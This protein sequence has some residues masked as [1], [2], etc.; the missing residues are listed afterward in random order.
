MQPAFAAVAPAAPVLAE[1][2]LWQRL[3]KSPT[4]AARPNAQRVGGQAALPIVAA[5]SLV[6]WRRR[7]QH[8]NRCSKSARKAAVVL[9]DIV[10]GKLT[11]L[12]DHVER[13]LKHVGVGSQDGVQ[14]E[15]EYIDKTVDIKNG[16]DRSWSLEEH[17]FTFVQDTPEIIDFYNEMDI[18]KKYYPA[19]QELVKKVTGASKV[20]AFYHTVRSHE[21]IPAARTRRERGFPVEAPAACVHVDYS[22]QCAQRCLRNLSKPPPQW[23]DPRPLLGFKP[24]IASSEADEY[25]MGGKRWMIV[26]VWRNISAV[27]VQRTPVALCDGRTASLDDI[28]TFQARVRRHSKEYY[29]SAF[30]DKHEWFYFPHA[31]RDEAILVKNWDSWGEAFARKAVKET[32]P[33]TFAFHTA[34]EQA[35]TRSDAPHR[36]SM[37]VR[38]VAFF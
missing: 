38:L 2:W 18:C 12:A 26:N 9:E 20:F 37:E 36:E 11:Y 13:S 5:G 15:A 34:F 14:I 30:S 19:C 7:K 28:V 3:H 29:F 6:L 23:P 10:R 33:T 35:G 16:R 1:T 17:G 25:I 8:A 32:V 31:Q 27:P 4:H 24:M 21:S 22:S